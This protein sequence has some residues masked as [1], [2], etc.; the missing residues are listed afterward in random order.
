MVRAVADVRC[1]AYFRSWPT[2]EAEACIA[3]CWSGLIL[4]RSLEALEAEL[5]VSR[6]EK[7]LILRAAR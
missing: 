3:A 4:K 7:S 5:V 2:S 1:T 6:H